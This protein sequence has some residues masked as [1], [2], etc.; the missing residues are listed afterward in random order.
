MIKQYLF[1]GFSILLIIFSFR[2]LSQNPIRVYAEKVSD[3]QVDLYIV[4][5]DIVP[6][7]AELDLELS[8]MKADK[9]LPITVVAK[10]DRPE[11]ILT[12]K[13]GGSGKFGYKSKFAYYVGDVFNAKHDANVVYQLPYESGQ[14]FRVDQGYYGE[15]SH[16]GIKAIDFT[17][18]EG[19]SIRA[20]RSGVVIE[21]KEDSNKGCDKEKCKQEANFV[22]IY[23]EDGSFA[24]YVHLKKDGVSVN[25]GD[26]VKAGDIIG[27]SG[28]T[29]FTTGPHL[30]FEV[31]VPQEGGRT[32]VDTKFEYEKGKIGQLSE[33]KKYK[34][35]K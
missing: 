20:A 16:A 14:E 6:Y 34:A 27:Y 31:N 35:F 5:D 10:P 2:S 8:N 32:S 19:T 11:K 22:Q 30:H 25:R 13:A 4:S 9:K 1:Y 18:S 3:S 12:L 7:T 15:F 26:Q 33:G 23:H 21:L 17:M 28:N 29:G 24:K